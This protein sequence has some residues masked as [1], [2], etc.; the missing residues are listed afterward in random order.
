MPRGVI[1]NQWITS[2][3]C[4]QANLFYETH[5]ALQEWIRDTENVCNLVKNCY[6]ANVVVKPERGKALLWYNHMVDNSTGW[7]G[8]LDKYSFH[9]GCDVRRGTKWIANHWISLSEDR[10]KDI[11][12]WIEIGQY[13]EQ[14]RKMTNSSSN[15][16]IEEGYHQ[17]L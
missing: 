3:I 1:W 9:G 11:Q 8:E 4:K 10:Q 16:S 17:E 13:E 2:T 12:N 6:K 15:E 7:L 14:Q 5:F